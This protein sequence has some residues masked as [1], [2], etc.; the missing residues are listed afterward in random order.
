MFAARGFFIFDQPNDRT[1]EVRAGFGFDGS[2]HSGIS[3]K[4][5]KPNRPVACR[6]IACAYLAAGPQGIDLANEDRLQPPRK[7]QSAQ[8]ETKR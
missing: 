3:S 2:G 6:V 1:S 7:P 5:S 8:G 4:I